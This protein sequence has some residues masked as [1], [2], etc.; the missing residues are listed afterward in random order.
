MNQG[1]SLIGFITIVILYAVVGVM[2]A[3]GT[4]CISRRRFSPRAEQ[5]FYALFLIMIAVFYLAFTAYFGA[6]SAW[7][8]ETSAVVIFAA[9][10]LLGVRL[11]I[12]LIIGFPLHGLW[13]LLHE[14]QPQ[15]IISA[16]EPG[17]LTSIPLAYGIFCVA[18]D[19]CVAGYAF[20]RQP[21]WSAAWKS[22]RQ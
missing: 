11:P 14:V 20:T 16:L 3:V 18:Y 4:I 10:S 5:I 1:H 6:T 12:A 21:A 17:K 8:V 9:I 2:A 22:T 7:T 13:D 19:F 15:G